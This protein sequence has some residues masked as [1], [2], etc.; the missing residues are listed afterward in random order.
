MIILETWKSWILKQINR[1]IK[2]AVCFRK[3]KSVFLSDE[4]SRSAYLADTAFFGVEDGDFK[5]PVFLR[6]V[7]FRYL[8]NNM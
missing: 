4:I 7:Y 5:C 8:I 3:V 2:L 6:Y 1:T